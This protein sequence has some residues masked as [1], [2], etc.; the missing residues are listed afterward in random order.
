ML[1]RRKVR[2]SREN[3]AKDLPLPCTVYQGGGIWHKIFLLRIQNNSFRLSVTRKFP[4][5]QKFTDSAVA[6]YCLG[7]KNPEVLPLNGFLLTICKLQVCMIYTLIPD[8]CQFPG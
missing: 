7:C 6:L 8:N 5:M 3:S 2:F 4:V 1:K